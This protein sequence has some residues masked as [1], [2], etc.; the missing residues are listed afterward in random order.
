MNNIRHIIIGSQ[1]A[2]RAALAGTLSFYLAKFFNLQHPIYALVAAII[3]TD[4]SPAETTRL[5]SQ[6]LI[7]TGIGAICGVALSNAFGQQN[8]WIVGLGLLVAM[9]SCHVCNLSAG[10]KVAGYV[11]ALVILN[12]GEDPWSHALYR[13]IET[14]LGI[15]VAWV[16][17][18][19][20]RLI[21][22]GELGDRDKH[23]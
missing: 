7:A 9:I 16:L 21:H 5:G 12:E 13:M 15:A 6:R 11:S 1:L 19:I 18:L 17:S 23:T 4:L 22:V 10:A 2:L 14:V 20:P 8:Q 3:V